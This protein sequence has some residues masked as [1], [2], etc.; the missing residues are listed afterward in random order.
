MFRDLAP[1]LL[2][3]SNLFPMSGKFLLE[4]VNKITKYRSS[5]FMFWDLAPLSPK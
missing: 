3:E 1:L 2:K 4:D 5:P